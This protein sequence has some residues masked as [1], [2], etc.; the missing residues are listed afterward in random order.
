MLELLAIYRHLELMPNGKELPDYIPLVVEFLSLRA[1][2]EDPIREKL[3]KEYILPI[4][5]P[6]RAKLEQLETP[7]FYLLDALER[8]LRL[9]LGTAQKEVNRV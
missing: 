5:P 8:V 3:I 9:D 4:L 6:I 1:G 2:S 7:Y